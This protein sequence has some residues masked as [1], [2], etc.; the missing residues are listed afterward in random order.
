MYFRHKRD[1]LWHETARLA[2]FC[3]GEHYVVLVCTWQ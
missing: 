1:T 3:G 2:L